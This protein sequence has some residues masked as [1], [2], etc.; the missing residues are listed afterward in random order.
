MSTLRS[1]AGADSSS[2]ITNLGRNTTEV[3]YFFG[4]ETSTRESPVCLDGLRQ[5]DGPRHVVSGEVLRWNLE[6]Q[7]EVPLAAAVRRRVAERDRLGDV[8]VYNGPDGVAE[9]E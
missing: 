5:E 3:D 2:S 4:A 1:T 9:A 7:E 8:R 6:H